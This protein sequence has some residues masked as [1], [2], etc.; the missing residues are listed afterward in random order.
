MLDFLAFPASWINT[1]GFAIAGVVA[2]LLFTGVADWLATRIA[3]AR[4]KLGAFRSLQKSW[5]HLA[6]GIVIA[7]VLGGFIEEIALRG[8]VLRGL[9]HLLL[10]DVTASAA[11]VLAIGAAALV[12]FVIHLY[13]GLRGALIVGQ[14]SVLFGIVYVASG[15]DLWAAILCHGLYDTV[16]F[17]RFA[18][19][20]SRY[21]QF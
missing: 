12:G 6:A 7:W 4:P 11:A 17:I 10:A 19:R 15:H 5:L 18:R 9:E 16:A 3:P 2:A 20:K 14:L 1:L 21:S 13:Q 8:I